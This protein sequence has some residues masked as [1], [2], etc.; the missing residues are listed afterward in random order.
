MERRCDVRQG[1]EIKKFKGDIVQLG[2]NKELLME[3]FEF[4]WG[5]EI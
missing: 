5:L 1:L 3:E 4:E 2:G